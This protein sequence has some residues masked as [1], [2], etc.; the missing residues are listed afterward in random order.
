MADADRLMQ[1]RR[2]RHRASGSGDQQTQNTFRPVNEDA[3]PPPPPSPTRIPETIVL[4][5]GESSQ[6]NRNKRPNNSEVPKT[7]VPRWTILEED[8][9]SIATPQEV[10]AIAPELCRGMVLPRDREFYEAPSGIDSSIEM[11]S[12]LALVRFLLFLFLHSYLLAN[13]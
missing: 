3:I 4:E 6:G 11:L 5:G 8:A 10:K 2:Q 12:H 13:L 9:I 1:R 7:Y